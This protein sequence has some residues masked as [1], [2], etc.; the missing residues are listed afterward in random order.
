MTEA[1]LVMWE[2]RSERTV[3]QCRCA[4]GNLLS[5]E[6]DHGYVLWCH[7]CGG[8]MRLAPAPEV[9]PVRMRQ[10]ELGI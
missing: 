6:E 1:E 2:L 4:A 8:V 10:M 3:L 7:E 5:V 9:T